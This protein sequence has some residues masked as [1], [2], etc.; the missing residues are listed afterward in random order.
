M[1][2]IF[3]PSLFLYPLE[4]LALGVRLGVCSLMNENTSSQQD[5]MEL[6][7]DSNTAS[8]HPAPGPRLPQELGWIY[9]KPFMPNRTPYFNARTFT[10]STLL[11]AL[12]A[13][14]FPV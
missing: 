6:P 11:T 3:Y 9:A 7:L 10:A 2:P 8:I 4:E 14:V 5:T 13:R 1:T 12:T